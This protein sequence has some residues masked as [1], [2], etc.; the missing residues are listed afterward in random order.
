MKTLIALSLLLSFS[1][2]ADFADD[3]AKFCESTEAKSLMGKN[4]TCQLVLGPVQKNEMSASCEGK[5]ADISCRVMMLKTFNTVSMTLICG[6]VDS[7]LLA[8]VLP[9]E[10][11]SYNISA[12]IKN[13]E[14]K[15]TTLND[16]NEYHLLSN[17]ALDVHLTRGTKTEGRMIMTLQDKMIELKNV[18]CN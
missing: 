13:A 7:P 16:P 11:V 12:V 2:F 5:L 3:H 14:G 1:A 15:I 8:Q 4:G 17:P 6:D 18:T 10:I 9:A